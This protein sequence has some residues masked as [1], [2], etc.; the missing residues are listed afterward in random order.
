MTKEKFI[1]KYGEEAL[2]KLREQTR[3]WKQD[4]KQETHDHFKKWLE[5]QG[6]CKI[7]NRRDT[8]NYLADGF[9][10]EDVEGYDGWKEH[11]VVHHKWEDLGY[12]RKRLKQ[13]GHYYHCEPW[14]LVCMSD[15][16]HKIHHH[17]L[18]K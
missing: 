1:A 9:K 2:K 16:E 3:K 5:K 17:A 13:M 14:E 10:W 18:K 12:S 7:R 11:T 8:I 15:R 6:G 4:H